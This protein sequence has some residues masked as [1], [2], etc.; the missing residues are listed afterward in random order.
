MPTASVAQRVGIFTAGAALGAAAATFA[1][2]RNDRIT[3]QVTAPV[4]AP[5]IPRSNEILRI[6]K[7]EPG[8]AQLQG[9]SSDVL[10]YGNP[11]E[12]SQPF[13]NPC[14]DSKRIR[15]DIPPKAL[16]ADFEVFQL[17]PP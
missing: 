15:F 3:V 4:S 6:P 1:Q 17:S 5:T 7:G 14:M 10:K 11:G 9:G 8:L 12:S 2:K 13:Y 16:L